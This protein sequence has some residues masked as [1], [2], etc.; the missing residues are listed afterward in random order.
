MRPAFVL[1]LVA[2][3]CLAGC[4]AP[5]QTP[6]APLASATTLASAAAPAAAP[7]SASS[8]GT[9]STAPAIDPLSGLPF[10]DLLALPPQAAVTVAAIER[11]GPFPFSQDGIAFQNREGI[12][13]DMPTGYYHEYTV[14]TPGASDRGAR[15]IVT[16]AHGELY[17]SSDHY[18]SFLRIRQ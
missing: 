7:A 4:Q 13:P 18:D 12:L 2:L 8:V 11:D 6:A 5:S 16:G 14:A 17:W 1:A 10:V 15:R 3:L 9:T